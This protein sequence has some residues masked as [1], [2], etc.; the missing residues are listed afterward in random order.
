MSESHRPPL[1]SLPMSCG[2]SPRRPQQL[3]LVAGAHDR[4]HSQLRGG[5][6]AAAPI[7]FRVSIPTGRS[8]ATPVREQ[9]RLDCPEQQVLSDRYL[10]GRQ[11]AVQGRHQR[12]RSQTTTACR[13]TRCRPNRNYLWQN[14]THRRACPVHDPYLVYWTIGNRIL[15]GGNTTPLNGLCA[16][17]DMHWD[18]F[19]EPRLPA[20]YANTKARLVKI[21]RT[22][23]SP[24]PASV[25]QQ[26]RG[27]G[28]SFWGM[29]RRAARSP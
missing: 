26:R 7:G 1:N 12:Q 9:R 17:P 3:H 24:A 21:A 19:R 16:A 14:F 10:R 11:A 23:S 2:K 5:Q 22:G 25:S 27:R 4:A 18:N 15:C 6:A 29:R 8:T 13:T 20:V 28:V